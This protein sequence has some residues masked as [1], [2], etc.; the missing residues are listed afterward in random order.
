MLPI[1]SRPLPHCTADIPG[2]TLETLTILPGYWRAM[3]ESYTI[4]ECF[5]RDACNGGITGAGR[6]C[7]HGYSGP[8][9]HACNILSCICVCLVHCVVAV[10][11]LFCK[12]MHIHTP[13]SACAW[14]VFAD[15]AVCEGGY[16]TSL[17]HTCTR[18]SSSR[19]QGLMAATVVAGIAAISVIAA[20][21]RYLLSVESEEWKIGRFHHRV[22]QAFPLQ[23]FKIIVVMRQILTQVCHRA[24]L[25]G[26][27]PADYWC[28]QG[29][30][31]HAPSYLCWFRRTLW[32]EWGLAAF[33]RD[34]LPCF[35]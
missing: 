30:N 9:E 6:F 31:V 35:L 3:N 18:C 8:C 5:N 11:S 27:Q 15:C 28:V 34:F 17:A 23:A 21:F 25:L 19:R 2:V 13:F 26:L 33:F 24:L 14:P 20:A 32:A 4:L 16:S 22:L 12:R 7:D 1:C 29:F 10:P